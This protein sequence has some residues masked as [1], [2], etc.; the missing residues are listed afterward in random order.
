[1]PFLTAARQFLEDPG[2]LAS[3]PNLDI[4]NDSVAYLTANAVGLENAKSTDD[5]I[6]F[7]NAHGHAINRHQWQ[8]NVLGKLR[9]EGI[10]IASDRVKGLYIIDTREE[11]ER[12]YIQYGRRIAKQTFRLGMLRLL[13]DTAHWEAA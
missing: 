6:A 1:M 7:L 12:F 10:F 8:I 11:A 3:D 5:V 9:E 13:I 2:E 4:M